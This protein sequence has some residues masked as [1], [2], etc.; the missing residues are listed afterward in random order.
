MERV[1]NRFSYMRIMKIL[2]ATHGLYDVIKDSE[3]LGLLEGTNYQLSTLPPDGANNHDR[4]TLRQRALFR[5]GMIEG[6]QWLPRAA[7]ISDYRRKQPVEYDGIMNL[8]TDAERDFQINPQMVMNA[9][10]VA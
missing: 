1:K 8:L 3:A 10:C 2:S 6:G 4:E 7:T 5:I 9:S